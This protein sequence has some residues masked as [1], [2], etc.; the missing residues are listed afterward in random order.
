MVQIDLLHQE[1]LSVLSV[2]EWP[3]FCIWTMAESH[4]KGEK[5]FAYPLLDPYAT[6]S[7]PCCSEKS[8]SPLQA[9]KNRTFSQL[10]AAKM[11]AEFKSAFPKQYKALYL[12]KAVKS[13]LKLGLPGWKVFLKSCFFP[14]PLSWHPPHPISLFP[15]HSFPPNIKA[16]SAISASLFLTLSLPREV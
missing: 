1:A 2:E 10:C 15:L 6:A 5:G 12:L 7:V 14:L 4:W 11:L 16:F 8:N 13:W 9:K 3:V